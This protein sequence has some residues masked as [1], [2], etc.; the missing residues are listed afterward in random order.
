MYEA[1]TG[2]GLRLHARL[3]RYKSYLAR[4]GMVVFE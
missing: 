4:C 3:A 1:V 2:V